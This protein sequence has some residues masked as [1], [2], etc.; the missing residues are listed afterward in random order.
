MTELQNSSEALAWAKL[1]N[2]WWHDSGNLNGSVLDRISHYGQSTGVKCSAETGCGLSTVIL[3]NIARRHH[4]FTVASGNSL[5]RV[6]SAPHFCPRRVSFIVGPSQLTLP[7]FSFVEQLDLV[8]IDGAH[9][10][11]FPQLD[12]YYFYPHI[13]PGGILIVDDI[14][15]PIVTQMYDILKQDAMWE[16]LEDVLCT[17]FFKRTDAPLFDPC[18]DNWWQQ[19]YNKKHFKERESLEGVLGEKWWER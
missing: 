4:C 17:A 13:S 2:A 14:H 6:Q 3:S 19:G 12:Y 15:I 10:F 1:Q 7:R 16:H 11:P 18:G 5:G 8:L 9:G